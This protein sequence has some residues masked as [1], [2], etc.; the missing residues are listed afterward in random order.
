MLCALADGGRWS[1]THP[2]VSETALHAA[3]RQGHAEAVRIL[4]EAGAYAHAED[5]DGNLALHKAASGGHLQI[6]KQLLS[7]DQHLRQHDRASLDWKNHF[8]AQLLLTPT[9]TALRK[10]SYFCSL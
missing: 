5:G 10:R 2:K 7:A 9:P 3:A 8:G 1:W 6:L 4:L